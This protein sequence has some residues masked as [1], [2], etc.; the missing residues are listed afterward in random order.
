LGTSA[1]STLTD[2]P[3]GGVVGIHGD[4]G[5]PQLIPGDPSHGCVR[6]HHADLAWLAPRLS[7]GAPVDIV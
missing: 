7:L 2:W 5:E 3:G 6:M 1:Y 4:F